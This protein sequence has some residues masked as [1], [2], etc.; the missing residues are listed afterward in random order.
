M[1]FPPPLLSPPPPLS[2]S[3]SLSQQD[4]V[5]AE[6]LRQEKSTRGVQNWSPGS[7]NLSSGTTIISKVRFV[8]S[9]HR[10]FLQWGITDSWT[11][12][13]IEGRVLNC[14]GAFLVH[15]T[16]PVHCMSQPFKYYSTGC[17]PVKKKFHNPP[18]PITDPLQYTLPQ[19]SLPALKCIHCQGI[20][21]GHTALQVK[22]TIK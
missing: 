2:L 7:T 21:N 6:T 9:L 14:E 8:L 3:L 19:L 5:L 15:E 13:A 1:L 17:Q 22:Q 16:T 10:I 20:C 18:P 11:S 12:Q 4:A